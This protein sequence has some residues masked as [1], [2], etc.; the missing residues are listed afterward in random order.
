M[1]VVQK[2]GT[3]PSFRQTA[4]VIFQPI[5]RGPQMIIRNTV[6][7]CYQSEDNLGHMEDGGPALK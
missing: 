6:T 5:S 7:L 2:V 3:T 1:K 4:L